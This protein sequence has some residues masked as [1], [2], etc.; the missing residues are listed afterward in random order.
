MESGK[1]EHLTQAAWLQSLPSYPNATA[2][3]AC[4]PCV[5]I[6][7][8]IHSNVWRKWLVISTCFCLS[9]RSGLPE[10][11][12]SPPAFKFPLLSLLFFLPRVNVVIITNSRLSPLIPQRNLIPS[13][14]SPISLPLS[15][16]LNTPSFSF[17]LSLFFLFLSPF[18][19][20]PA[21][22]LLSLSASC[23]PPSFPLSFP[24]PIEPGSSLSQAGGQ[25][26]FSP[27]S[28]FLLHGC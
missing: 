10:Y 13:A 24:P 5:W 9:R 4:P 3:T 22:F 12:G 14:D 11:L 21:Y 2:L 25:R 8:G 6:P 15:Y 23:A 1:V 16:S 19:P 27:A 20:F 17:P 7:A 18:L 28:C 26:A